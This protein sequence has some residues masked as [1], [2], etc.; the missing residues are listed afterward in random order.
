MSSDFQDGAL[1]IVKKVKSD[2][3]VKMNLVVEW[4]SVLM[5]FG[6]QCVMMVGM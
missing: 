3:L 1:A 4:R 2:L 6:E 5:I